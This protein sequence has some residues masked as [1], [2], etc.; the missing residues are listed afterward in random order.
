MVVDCHSVGLTREH[1]AT[2]AHQVSKPAVTRQW[3][4]RAAMVREDRM[5]PK[6]ARCGPGVIDAS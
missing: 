6:T 3:C 5:Q 1:G 2:A 4:G